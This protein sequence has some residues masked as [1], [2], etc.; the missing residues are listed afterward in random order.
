M[1]FSVIIP[2]Y[3]RVRLIATCVNGILNTNFKD[4]E[5]IIV[6][7]GSTDGS[8]KVCQELAAKHQCIKVFSQK[9]SGVSAARNNGLKHASGE[10]ILFSD[11]DDTFSPNALDEINNLLEDESDMLM[12]GASSAFYTSEGLRFSPHNTE[13]SI[14][15]LYGNS[16]I[17][18]WLFTDYNPYVNPMYSVWAKVFRRDFITK[19]NLRFREDLSLGE[20]QVFVCAYLRYVSKICF[21]NAYYYYAIS[22]PQNMRTSGLG[23]VFRST[24]DFLYNQEANYKA[25]LGLYE[26]TQVS[27]V[28]T[29]AVNYILDRPITRILFRNAVL[30]NSRRECY[31]LLKQTVVEKIKPVLAWEYDNI[32]QLRDSK[33]ARCVQWIMTG[34]LT[35]LMLYAY[36]TQNILQ[37]KRML[38]N[39]LSTIKHRLLDRS[40]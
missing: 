11:S 15:R 8:L 18:Q 3:N 22:W 7:D 20:D 21:T 5:I 35:K 14:K 34:Q 27:A 23:S 17:V 1:K 19:H 40:V 2:V 28:R 37:I 4:F 38:F 25:L 36:V 13:P 31:A 12:F 39:Q 33:I 24:E 9:N 32:A 10:Y 26:A 16:D 6:D 29:Y 30:S